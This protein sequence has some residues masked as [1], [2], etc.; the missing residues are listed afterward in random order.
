MCLNYID[1]FV[2]VIVASVKITCLKYE[3]VLLSLFVYIS[4]NNPGF[5]CLVIH[6]MNLSQS[7]CC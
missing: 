7:F 3:I 4:Q 1:F 5:Y 2:V 6:F